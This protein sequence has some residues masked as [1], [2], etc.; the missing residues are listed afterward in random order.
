MCCG[1]TQSP[2]R[3]AYSSAPEAGRAGPQPALPADLDRRRSRAVPDLPEPPQEPR[4]V[5]TRGVATGL[6][7]ISASGSAAQQPGAADRA[8]TADKL[9]VAYLRAS[10]ASC[11]VETSL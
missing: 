6:G 5:R 2:S 3:A 9:G 4:L 7:G 1:A 11:C 10:P 8:S